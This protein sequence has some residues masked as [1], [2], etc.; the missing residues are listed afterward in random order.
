MPRPNYEQLDSTLLLEVS[1]AFAVEIRGLYSHS[2]SLHVTEIESLLSL[3]LSDHLSA[4]S[5]VEASVRKLI[6]AVQSDPQ[7]SKSL[8]NALMDFYASLCQ[9]RSFRSHMCPD[10]L[11]SV[12]HIPLCRCLLEALET[13]DQIAWISY[14]EKFIDNNTVALPLLDVLHPQVAVNNTDALQHVLQGLETGDSHAIKVAWKWL[15]HSEEVRMKFAEP[16]N[17]VPA[18]AI[19]GIRTALDDLDGFSTWK[20]MKKSL[21]QHRESLAKSSQTH[22]PTKGADLRPN[23]QRD[24]DVWIGLCVVLAAMHASRSWAQEAG[25]WRNVL[26]LQRMELTS[27]V[28]RV[29]ERQREEEVAVVQQILGLYT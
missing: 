28:R 7:P 12:T 19:P 2:L 10:L 20:D 5:S 6:L 29:R 22:S 25:G 15:T 24:R 21:Q 3:I 9:I 16:A 18:R 26:R 13:T 27:V 11:Q 1:L 23:Q 8:L 4:I 17:Y 14:S